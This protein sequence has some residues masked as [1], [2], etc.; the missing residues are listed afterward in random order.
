MEMVVVLSEDSFVDPSTIN[1]RELRATVEAARM[2]PHPPDPARFRG[3]RDR[4][5]CA[6]LA[7]GV[8][9]AGC[10]PLAGYIPANERYEAIYRAAAAKGVHLVNTPTQYQTAMEF[11]RFYPLLGELT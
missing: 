9:S 6:C 1:G 3:V 10:G 11:D 8:R 4:R 7:A 2:L 5:E